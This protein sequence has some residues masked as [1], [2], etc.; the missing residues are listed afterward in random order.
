ME[1][2]PCIKPG[3]LEGSKISKLGSRAFPSGGLQERP[4]NTSR[5]G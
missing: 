5:E 4:Q 3:S 1:R 2:I